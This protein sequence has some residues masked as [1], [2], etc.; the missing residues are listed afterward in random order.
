MTKFADQLYNDLMREHGSALAEVKPAA[1][2]RRHIASR[3]VLL[4]AGAGGIAVAA[5]VGTL[6][7][8]GGSPAAHGGSPAARGGTPAYALTA[9]PDGTIKLAVYRA[10][11]I[12]QANARLRQLGDGNVVVVPLQAGC[13]S[14]S[15][16]PAPAVLPNGPISVSNGKS[17][18]GSITVNASGVPAGDILVIATETTRQYSLSASR[19]TS[20]PAPSCVSLSASPSGSGRASGSG[21]SA[22][23]R[24]PTRVPRS[25][26]GPS[27]SKS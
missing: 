17:S 6:A 10:S 22:A 16:L 21:P 9:S 4:A 24:T 7:A 2:S 20:P 11:G 14:M 18:D 3:P 8:S 5:A 27:L 26:S 23:H 13:P 12:A 19:L 1:A 15:S 25:G